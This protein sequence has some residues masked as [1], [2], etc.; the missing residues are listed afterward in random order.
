VLGI[1]EGI[2]TALA[3][4]ILFDIQVWAA[5]NA[6]RLAVWQPPDSM[7]EVVIVATHIELP[8]GEGDDWCDVL[9]HD[10]SVRGYQRTLMSAGERQRT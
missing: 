8:V 2:E 10:R 7:R 3:A 6:N 4:S 5:L 1:A 9:A